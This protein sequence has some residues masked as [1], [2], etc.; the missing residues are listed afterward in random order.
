VRAFV[1]LVTAVVLFASAFVGIR[2]VLSTDAFTP[3][4]LT[5]GRLFVASAM[6]AVLALLSGGVRVPARRDWP[7][8]IALGAL[9]Q[10][11][12]QVLLSTGERTVESGTAALLVSCSP[13]LASVIAVALLGE[14]LTWQG[15]LGTGVAFIGAGTIA[16]AA[17]VSLHMGSGVLMVVAATFIWAG[18]QVTLKTVAGSYG[19]L[20]LTAW[21]TW[22]ASVA[23]LPFSLDVPAAVAAAPASAT[24]AVV[25]MGAASSVGGFLAW[26][27]ATK[28]LPVVVSSNALFGVPVA[29]FTIGWL[30][31]GEVPA[32]GALLGGAVAVAGVTLMQL[33]GRPAREFAPATDS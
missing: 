33:R 28:R 16:S 24:L 15:W 17:G 30:V 25:W 13:I 8:F 5:A 7:A 22:I 2:V 23:L 27:F 20:E 4:Q 9:G 26:S 3:V 14:R 19:P 29:A 6:L 12:Y 18:Y 32:A 10:T 21:P 11:L 31:L 1:A